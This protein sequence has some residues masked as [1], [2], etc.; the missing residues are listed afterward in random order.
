ML[1]KVKG[2]MRESTLNVPV[3]KKQRKGVKLIFD[4]VPC[5]QQNQIL[6]YRM[7]KETEQRMEQLFV[8]NYGKW[9]GY[10]VKRG[11]QHHDAED[12]VNDIFA[13]LW[14]KRDELLLYPYEELEAY[15]MK[16]LKN[17]ISNKCR[18][19]KPFFPLIDGLFFEEESPEQIVLNQLDFEN[20]KRAV[21]MLPYPQREI[22]HMMYFENMKAAEV[23]QAL[24]IQINTIYTY[25]QRA[26]QKL[27][28]VLKEIE[29]GGD[30]KHGSGKEESGD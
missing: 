30:E 7:T 14:A 4:H 10:A 3:P 25:R 28:R 20:V 6:G 11:I 22:I 1:Y 12:I 16:A 29:E 27:R 15:A 9:S 17:S 8:E 13:A 23:S 24:G 5:F 19:E 26:T 2:Q 21:K 18:R